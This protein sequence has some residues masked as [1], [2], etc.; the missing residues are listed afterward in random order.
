MEVDKNIL[1]S[2]N[3]VSQVKGISAI[4]T[5]SNHGN[6]VTEII[7]NKPSFI[8]RWGTLFFFFLL[9]LIGFLAWFIEYPDKVVAKGILH[10]INAP[11]EVIAQSGG[12]LTRLF[13]KENQG[14]TKNEVLGYMESIAN[15]QEIIALSRLMDTVKQKLDSNGVELISR[16]LPVP[17]N[18]LGELQSSNQNFNQAFI[19]FSNYLQDGFYL[20]KRLM[21]DNDMNYLQQL[22]VTLLQ[23]KSLLQQ[24]LQLTDTTFRANEILKEHKVISAMEYRNEKS[25]RIAKE[26][27]LPQ[28]NSS[29]ISNVNQQ[30]EKRKEIAELEN[31]IQQQENIFIQALN[32]F[33]SQVD[34]W[35]R[36]YLL[37]AAVDGK[38]TFAAFL[39]ENQQL[40]QGQTICYINPGNTDYYIE[41][42]IPQYNF[43][44]IKTS[45]KVLLKFPAYPYQ[46]FGSVK[47][48]IDIINTTPTDS[49]FLAK[50][51]MPEG[52]VTNYKKSIQYRTGL[53]VQAE[54]ITENMNLLQRLFYNLR[55]NISQ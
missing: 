38:V 43:G 13:V 41:V 21:L 8:V 15:P 34:E 5:F 55:K 14:V 24:D 4:N 20:R 27:S 28:I 7:S 54:I 46:E 31:Q 11:K 51:T 39:Q 47:G 1:N 50:V 26:M 42:L 10:S 9:L 12:K 25:K 17:Y 30:N 44:K 19:S 35:K 53:S 6:E 33:I 2:D 16:Y 23:Q 37:I 49:G 29:I 18:D 3:G 36:K 22:H 32:T 52:L 48:T 40:R 45:Q